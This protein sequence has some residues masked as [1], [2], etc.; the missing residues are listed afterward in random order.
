M[1]R[2]FYTKKGQSISG[3]YIVLLALAAVALVSMSVFVRRV[4][5]ARY[6]DANMLVTTKAAGA[7]EAGQTLQFEYEPYYQQSNAVTA[8]TSSEAERVIADQ[9]M[10]RTIDIKRNSGVSSTQIPF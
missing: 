7:L 1:L 10:E 5:Q 8:T 6:R 3:E 2:R 9:V 4:L